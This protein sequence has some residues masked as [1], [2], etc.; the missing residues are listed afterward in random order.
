MIDERELL[1]R[2]TT[3]VAP[4]ER[5]MDTLERR[6]DRR[7][8]NRR[9]GSAMLA[10]VI[11]A[12]GLVAVVEAFRSGKGQ[13]ADRI[14]PQTIDRLALHWAAPISSNGEV[15]GMTA[16]DGVIVTV[17]SPGPG[18]PAA[19]EGDTLVQAFA[20]DCG[21]EGASCE[22]VWTASVQGVAGITAD[23]DT[24]FVAAD[25][26]AAFPARCRTDGGICSPTWTAPLKPGGGVRP[27]VSDGV[28]YV[29]A[30]DVPR[31]GRIYAFATGCGSGGAVCEPIWKSRIVGRPLLTGPVVEGRV[32]AGVFASDER[33]DVLNKLY[34]FPV[35]CGT[36][37]GACEPVWEGNVAGQVFASMPAVSGG[38]LYIG[39]ARNA[40]LGT[41]RAYDAGCGVEPACQ[42]LWTI[43]QSDA[44]NIPA[45]VIAEGVLVTA[46][47]F[48]GRIRAWAIPQDG[49][50][51]T[52]RW[53][54]C[55]P[56][57]IPDAEP[58]IADGL[59]YVATGAGVEAYPVDCEPQQ[60]VCRPVWTSPGGAAG[61]VQVADG[62]VLVSELDGRLA[63]YGLRE[64]A[65]EP[66]SPA[67]RT[68]TPIFYG[69]VALVGLIVI[70]AR[71]RI[72]TR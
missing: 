6:R 10:L 40:D 1:E 29:A 67:S 46:A 19:P 72:R 66:P 70:A 41:I 12:G 14:T 39:T 52:L 4:P 51:A 60:G 16:T 50:E 2:A 38:V 22:P 69:V 62:L 57:A 24:V 56:L 45:P 68:W 27:V 37:G 44:L 30:D 42:P 59:V 48:S 58:V 31:A 17:G 3:R 13:S 43:R 33:I 11:A 20:E 28:V 7:R 61:V 8:R 9:I 53:T 63:V 32:Y 55:C 23:A 5:V 18:L 34:A 25:D 26:L 21:S 47:R 71:R 54:A 35:G 15:A 64:P 49:G 36:N 65:A